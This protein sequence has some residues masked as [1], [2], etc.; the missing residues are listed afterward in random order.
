MKQ[1]LIIIL[2]VFTNLLHAQK[3][4]TPIVFVHGMLGSGDTWVRP[5]QNFISQ[6]YSKDQLEVLDWNSISFN[7]KAAEQQLDSII[8]VVLNRTG[9][10]KVNLV[11]HSAGG[12]LCSN[13]LKEEKN[14]AKVNNYVHVG[15]FTLNKAPT[16][17]TLNLYSTE[18]KI[19]KGAAIE[20]AKNVALAELD[21]YEIATAI[22]SFK[23]MYGFFNSSTPLSFK[24][25]TKTEHVMLSGRVVS[26][27]EN[28]AEKNA[29]LEVYPFDPLTGERL[30]KKP[31]F[32]T[33]ANPQG[34]W[35]EFKA[36]A[37]THYEFIIK[38][39]DN[40]K[41][42]IHYYREPF[43][44]NNHWIYLRT[45]PQVGMAKMLLGNLPND[46]TQVALAVFSANKA[47]IHGRDE[48]TVNS[49]ALSSEVF[50]AESKTAIAFFLYDANKNNTTDANAISAF[51]ILPFMSGIDLYFT[52][53]NDPI[54]LQYNKRNLRVKPIPSDEGVM[55]VVFD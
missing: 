41:R 45:L 53:N 22:E 24:E 33:I 4:Y 32:T 18:D 2:V 50:A 48:L 7:N 19:V 25:E 14:A 15:S 43:S 11:G 36:N 54:H 27:G 38:P 44:N 6:G 1:F 21:H 39:A 31:V 13:Y 16:V 35:G 23:Q 40:T 42:V 20:G 52:P 28:K 3:N 55:V 26:L 29:S 9:A 10:H 12:N 17:R 46:E 51:R 30:T 34:Y 47:V 8:D 5:M 37:N 49:V